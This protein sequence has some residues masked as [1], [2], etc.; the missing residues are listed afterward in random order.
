MSRVME[1]LR[2]ES[3][4]EGIKIVAA[5]MVAAGKSVSE[6]MRLTGLS[7]EEIK[8]LRNC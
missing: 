6:I 8:K 7:K 4:R 1:E 2:I 5:N 3:I